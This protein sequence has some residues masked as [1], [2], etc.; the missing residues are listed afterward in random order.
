MVAGSSDGGKL[1]GAMIYGWCHG[2]GRKSPIVN[3]MCRSKNPNRFITL[4]IIGYESYITT[5]DGSEIR[6]THQL[7][8]RIYHSL[9]GFLS[10]SGVCLGFLPSSV[11]SPLTTVR[12][13]I[14]A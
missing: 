3:E 10:I 11:V 8:W 9:H 2:K 12:G 6:L 1:G 4:V 14:T 13:P 7:I 5:V